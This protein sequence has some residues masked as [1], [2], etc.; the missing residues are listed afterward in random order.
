VGNTAT[1]N[2]SNGC[3]GSTVCCMRPTRQFVNGTRR[4]LR[5]MENREKMYSSG[6]HVILV[7]NVIPQEEVYIDS[8][9]YPQTA[10][11]NIRID[12]TS[13]FSGSKLYN[14]HFDMLDPMEFGIP[15]VKRFM[16]REDL[17]YRLKNLDETEQE[18]LS[19]YRKLARVI[20]DIE[21]LG[22]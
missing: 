13:A 3:A 10:V 1:A 17:L 4:F 7:P 18:A 2:V 8:A 19:R 16:W 22:Y 9:L 11:D 12:F 14:Y 5:G 15:A 20:D 21:I 6:N